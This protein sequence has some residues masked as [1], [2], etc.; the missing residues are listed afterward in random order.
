MRPFHLAAE[1]IVVVA[2][3]ARSLPA[4]VIERP[5]VHRTIDSGRI[6]RLRLEGRLVEVKLLRPLT[7]ASEELR[8]CVYNWDPCPVPGNPGSV[9]TAPAANVG[10]I[11][12][13]R[14]HAWHG[15]E[16][17]G[18]IG[19]ILGGIVGAPD[20]D[21]GPCVGADC[22]FT[23]ALGVGIGFGILGALIGGRFTRWVPAP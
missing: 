12:V 14:S 10:R 3:G 6:V 11:E 13:Q 19:A 22:H 9:L 1:L 17:A 7:Q 21:F 15:F 4:Q 20:R 2:F 18:V 23:G 8:Y 5:L 16:I